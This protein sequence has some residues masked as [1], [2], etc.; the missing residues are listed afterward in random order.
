MPTSYTWLTHPANVGSLVK[1]AQDALARW[2]SIGWVEATA[3]AGG[4]VATDP[5]DTTF[6]SHISNSGTKTQQAVDARIQA[7]APASSGGTLNGASQAQLDA[8]AAQQSQL[9]STAATIEELSTSIV[10]NGFPVSGNLV[11]ETSS[12][13]AYTLWV[14]PFPCKVI[15]ADYVREYGDVVASASNALTVT[16]SRVPAGGGTAQAIV[17]KSTASEAM[18]ARATWSFDGAVWNDVTF[19]KGDYLR[20]NH[21]VTGTATTRFPLCITWRYSPIS[22][23]TP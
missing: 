12:G 20:I 23:V 4:S 2:K 15:A 17:A 19:A 7:V 8:L 11:T 5:L 21:A 1:V 22:P 3:P 6:S 16:L 14:A 13:S 18:T 9:M 10:L